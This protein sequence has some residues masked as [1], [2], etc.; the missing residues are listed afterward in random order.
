MRGFLDDAALVAAHR[1]P[2]R[3]NLLYCV[4]YRLQ[5]NRNLLNIETDKDVSEMLRLSALVR[6][7][8]HKMHAFVRFRKVM[9]SGDVLFTKHRPEVIDEGVDEAMDGADEHHLA[10]ETPFGTSSTELKDCEQPGDADECEH[11]VAWYPPD[12]RILALAAPFFA[13]ASQFCDGLF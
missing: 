11:F 1:S 6:H 3:W 10:T 7:D 12:N 5:D 8:L 2:E 13:N 4:L 9:K